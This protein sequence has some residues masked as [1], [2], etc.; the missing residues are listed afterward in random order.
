MRVYIVIVSLSHGLQVNVL[1]VVRAISNRQLDSSI[2]DS[3]ENCYS[4]VVP[5]YP[6][7]SRTYNTIVPIVTSPA[8][9]TVAK[10]ARSTTRE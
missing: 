8:V 10:P 3:S 9:P 7:L 2:R 4:C 5:R 6:M 1:S